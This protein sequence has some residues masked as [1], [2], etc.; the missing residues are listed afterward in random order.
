MNICPVWLE[1]E[2]KKNKKSTIVGSVFVPLTGKKILAKWRE[3]LEYLNM[4]SGE[5][6]RLF[7]LGV[8]QF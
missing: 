8:T 4:F 3:T 1:L 6:W 7:G 5:L 2:R